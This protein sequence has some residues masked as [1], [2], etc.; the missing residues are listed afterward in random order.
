MT[1][2]RVFPSHFINATL[3]DSSGKVTGAYTEI[4]NATVDDLAAK[5][6]YNVRWDLSILAASAGTTLHVALAARA[7]NGHFVPQPPPPPLAPCPTS[8]CGA[9]ETLSPKG[10]I[11]DLSEAPLPAPHAS[12]PVLPIFDCECTCAYTKLYGISFIL[13]F[14]LPNFD[15]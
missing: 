11:V 13:D 14:Q 6:W 5:V 8:L 4:L 1:F 3:L 15:E 9:I 2:S 12:H 7:S 10:S